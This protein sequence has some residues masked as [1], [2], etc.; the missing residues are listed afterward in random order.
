MRPNE[1]LL[2]LLL[3]IQTLDNVP[4]MGYPLRGVAQAESVTEH[5]WHV[6]FLIWTL[7]PEIPEVDA[8]RAMEMALVHDL[9]EVRVGDLPATAGRYFPDGAKRQ[10][11]AAAMAEL[12]APLPA[13]A[14]QLFADYQAGDSPEA[15]LVKACDKLQLMLKV[16]LYERWG[17]GGLKEFWHNPANFPDGGFPVVRRLFDELRQRRGRGLAAPEP[18]PPADG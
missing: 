18:S 16:S 15:R 12:L 8:L 10:A 1:D 9:A 6:I 7:A 14:Q 13:K 17:A 2:D 3:E 5:S 11:E 4:R